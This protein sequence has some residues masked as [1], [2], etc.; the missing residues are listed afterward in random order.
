MGTSLPWTGSSVQH[1]DWLAAS[2]WGAEMAATLISHGYAPVITIAATLT[3]DD[4]LRYA[5]SCAPGIDD[6]MVRQ[7]F[8]DLLTQHRNG[9]TRWVK[10]PDRN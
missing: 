1:L 5:V 7:V 3:I 6:T 2:E 10:G 9:T 8:E 4:E